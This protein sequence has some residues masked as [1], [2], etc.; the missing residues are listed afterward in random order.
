MKRF[1]D[2]PLGTDLGPGQYKAGRKIGQ[3]NTAI[4]LAGSAAFKSLAR[5]PGGIDSS[6]YDRPGP[7][8]Y[9]N[10]NVI[11]A[12]GVTAGRKTHPGKE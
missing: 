2:K 1:N 3:S 5:I 9:L 4:Q 8:E 7:G 6:S 12:I 10:D 11:K